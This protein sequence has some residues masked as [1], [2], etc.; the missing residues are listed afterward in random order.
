M[1]TQAK[2]WTLTEANTNER[3]AAVIMDAFNSA[4]A[5][6]NAAPRDVENHLRF[7]MTTDAG[8]FL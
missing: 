8:R 4:K 5:Y 2:I 1:Q 6:G 7:A 3:V